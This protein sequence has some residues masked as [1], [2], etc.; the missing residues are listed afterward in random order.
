MKARTDRISISEGSQ[1][2]DTICGV[3]RRIYEII[4]ARDPGDEVIRLL[5]K[6]FAMAKR[7]NAKLQTY[8]H[9]HDDKWYETHKLD[10]GD[11]DA[12]EDK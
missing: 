8:K 2:L 10:G 11:I 6:A 4:S 9:G 1:S 3:H 7:M 5:R 12:M